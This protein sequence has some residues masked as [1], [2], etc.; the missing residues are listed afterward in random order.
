MLGYGKYY[1]CYIRVYMEHPVS[2]RKSGNQPYDKVLAV[3]EVVA[4]WAQPITI[5]EIAQQTG[6]PLPTVH[7]LASQLE[8]RGLLKRQ[9]A[10][11]RYLVGPMLTSLSAKVLNAAFSADKIRSELTSL[12]RRI[13]EHCHLGVNQLDEITYVETARAE[14]SSGL[15]FAQGRRSPLHGSSIGK[16]F[17]AD[18]SDEEFESWLSRTPRKKLTKHTITTA[19]ALKREIKAVQQRG[20]AR[21]NEELVDGVVGCAVPIRDKSGL[22][23]A[24]LG[25]SAPQARVAFEDLKKMVPAMALTAKRVALH[26]EQK[27]ALPDE[28]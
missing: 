19:T 11:K 16:L 17:L 3:L 18:L 24:G 4:D 23:L 25:V 27:T 6:L 1:V 13:G 12:A 20:W 10:G 22:L 2:V 5:S 21:S 28:E 7:R 15:F 9:I 8:Y 26:L 14:L